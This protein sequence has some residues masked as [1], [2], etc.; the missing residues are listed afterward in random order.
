MASFPTFAVLAAQR[1]YAAMK[2]IVADTLRLIIFLGLPINVALAVLARP[3]IT[4]A[5]QRGEFD[6]NDTQLVAW[7]LVF[8]AFAII[9]ISIIEIVARAFYALEDTVTPVVV[10]GLQI[11]LTLGLG[12]WLGRV[13]FPA[14]GWQGVWRACAGIWDCKL[15][16]GGF[17]ICAAATQN[18]RHR[19]SA[20]LGRRM[21]H[22][23]RCVGDGAG[24]A[25]GAAVFRPKRNAAWLA[26][27]L[28]AIW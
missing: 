6:A 4:L 22:G 18:K 7:G 19:W 25:A 9:A 5:F 17:V 10:G 23:C 15:G 12:W 21:A 20:Y 28:A 26:H 14:A 1:D 13:L 3:T 24:D 2:R 16:G 8:F 11:V 27:P